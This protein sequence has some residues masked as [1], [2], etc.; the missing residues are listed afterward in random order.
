MRCG[1]S[2]PGHSSPSDRLM[3]AAARNRETVPLRVDD[4][5]RCDRADQPDE[6]RADHHAS[7]SLAAARDRSQQRIHVGEP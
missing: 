2:V 4:R 1:A 5:H 7:T 3:I 6:P